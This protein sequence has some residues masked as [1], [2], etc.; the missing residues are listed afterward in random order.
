MYIRTY[1]ESQCILGQ[2][3][4]VKAKLIS[5]LQIQSMSIGQHNF[6]DTY[7][8]VTRTVHGRLMSQHQGIYD[9]GRGEGVEAGCVW[10]GLMSPLSVDKG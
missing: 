7:S 2:I 4:K 9:R 3:L 6:W 10:T 8:L 1:I 5:Q